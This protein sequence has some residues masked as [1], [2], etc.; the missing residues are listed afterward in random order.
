M[1][2]KTCKY[3]RRGLV[4]DY[5]AL[6]SHHLCCVSPHNILINCAITVFAEGEVNFVELSNN[7]RDEVERGIIGQYSLSLTRIIVLVKLLR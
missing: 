4:I 2:G 1:Y 5:L 6:E 7:P 3:L